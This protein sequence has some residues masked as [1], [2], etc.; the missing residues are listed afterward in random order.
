MDVESV[1]ALELGVLAGWL[2]WIVLESRDGWRGRWTFAAVVA[3]AACYGLAWRSALEDIPRNWLGLQDGYL[4][5]MFIK[6]YMWEWIP[7]DA[8]SQHLASYPFYFFYVF[9]K[10]AAFLGIEDAGEAYRLAIVVTYWVAPLAAGYLIGRVYGGWAA[11]AVA[12]LLLAVYVLANVWDVY[13]KPHEVFVISLLYPAALAIVS[14][15]YR[16][17]SAAERAIYGATVGFSVG[18]Y[19]PLVL[20]LMVCAAAAVLVVTLEAGFGYLRRIARRALDPVTVISASV[21]SAPWIV[22]YGYGVVAHGFGPHV[23]F[24]AA[25]DRSFDFLLPDGRGWFYIGAVGALVL[26]LLKRGFSARLVA[27]AGLLHLAYFAYYVLRAEPATSIFKYH[28][29]MLGIAASVLGVYLGLSPVRRRSVAALVGV[30]MVVLAPALRA[31]L[32]DKNPHYRYS[33]ELSVARNEN[34]VL[35]EVVRRVDSAFGTHRFVYLAN[36]EFQFLNYYTKGA[37]VPYLY[38]NHTYVS[39]Y[40]RR[41]EQLEELRRLIAADDFEGFLGFLR[42]RRIALVALT[43]FGEGYPLRV[44]VNDTHR[45]PRSGTN[46]REVVVSL[47]EGWIAA[48]K[49]TEGARVL[50]EDSLNVV[51]AIKWPGP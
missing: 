39:A 34:Q 20:S 26:L 43:R 24:E 21:V 35:Q 45:R 51:V 4:Y 40:E 48:L 28:S 2:A 46:Q 42:A 15:R 31:H 10:L 30:V 37:P 7:Y 13:Q 41:G 49:E 27:L 44:I 38:Y 9:G 36:S 50:F 19:P 5:A 29:A 25:S 6:T 3:V 18:A 22:V 17:L 47:P 16:R 1:A 23:T 8:L 33:L 12:V 32:V 11:V 14:P